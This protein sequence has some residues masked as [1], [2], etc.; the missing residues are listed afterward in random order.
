V[1]P[2][3]HDG[4]AC[5][6][7]QNGNGQDDHASGALPCEGNGL[8]KGKF[9]LNFALRPSIARFIHKPRMT[10]AIGPAIVPAKQ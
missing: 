7:Q 1:A 8:G 5:C 10:W 2:A 6:S 3:R 4:R 9:R